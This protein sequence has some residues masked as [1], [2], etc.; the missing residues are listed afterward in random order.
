MRLL[1]RILC[2]LGHHNWYVQRKQ[3]GRFL[4]PSF[5]NDSSG[6]FFTWGLIWCLTCAVAG[7]LT[8]FLFIVAA[9]YPS[10]TVR[11]IQWMA[12]GSISVAVSA[13]LLSVSSR[14]NDF[15]DA[16][17]LK[18][19]K[20]ELSLTALEREQERARDYFECQRALKIKLDP[21][22]RKKSIS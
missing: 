17:C 12:A 8:L 16:I 18:C 3:P 9:S 13:W 19:R 11:V 2:L 6:R 1:E 21:K 14:R 22:L 5:F 7:F 20:T 15:R 10:V 4:D